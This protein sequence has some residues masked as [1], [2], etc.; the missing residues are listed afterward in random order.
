M[1]I[2]MIIFILIFASIGLFLLLKIFKWVFQKKVRMIGL[3]IL[4]VCIAVSITTYTL[5]FVKMELIQSKVYPN[6]YLIKNPVKDKKIVNKAIEEKI[7]Q[8]MNTQLT[9][10]NKESKDKQLSTL[11]F[12]EYSKGDWGESGT[13]YFIEHKERQDG[14]TAELLEYYPE[15]LIANFSLQPCKNDS[16]NYFGK[17]DYYNEVR[18]IKT[19]TLL[20]TCKKENSIFIKDSSQYSFRFLKEI[21]KSKMK[22]TALIDNILVLEE[23]DTISF[24]DI[25]SIGKKKVLTAKKGKLAIAL[26]IKRINQ[27]TIDYKIEMVEF[28]KANYNNQGQADLS[29]HF[30]FG[31]ETDTSSLSGTSYFSTEFSNSQDSCYTYIRLGKEEK[32]GT[33]LQGK[34]IK[35][36]NRKIRDIGLDN[37][38]TLIEK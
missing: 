4:L 33:Y 19:D 5:F 7:T 26:T 25:P 21:E 29:P 16:S 9:G 17:V 38:P 34:I 14:M 37:F 12:Y 35:N 1:G 31:S 13:A 27:T 28:G 23:N 32:L 2:L 6:L 15:Y 11:S 36:C 18:I 10:K 22:T 30:Y 24:P 3:L 8:R 20:N